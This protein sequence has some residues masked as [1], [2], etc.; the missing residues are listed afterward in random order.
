MYVPYLTFPIISKHVHAPTQYF[1]YIP[2]LKPGK[3]RIRNCPVFVFFLDFFI[4]FYLNPL[5]CRYFLALDV[6]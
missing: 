4:L 1:M 6:T 2:I 3:F 5:E